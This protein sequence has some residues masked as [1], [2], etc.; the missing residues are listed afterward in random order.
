MTSRDLYDSPSAG[1]A[2][3]PPADER[4]GNR[5][6]GAPRQ[7]AIAGGAFFLAAGFTFAE[8]LY[9]AAS[10]A[11]VSQP[12]VILPG[13]IVLAIVMLTVAIG[14]GQGKLWAVRLFRRLSYGAMACYLPILALA[15]YLNAGA[16]PIDTGLAWVMFIFAVIKLPC[17]VII[18]RAL[19][20]VRW[21]DPES[22]PHEWEPS[23]RQR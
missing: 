19:K 4:P 21:L 20:Q 16:A 15:F 12:E 23:A 17:F 1:P 11:G 13:W 3:Q 5:P 14:V 18:Y 10:L 9:G 8:L 2:G 22:L 6:P 7:A